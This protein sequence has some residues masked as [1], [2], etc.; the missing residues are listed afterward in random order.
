MGK[1]GW[2]RAL[3]DRLSRGA[4]AGEAERA[5]LLV[6]AWLVCG[7]ILLLTG[8]LYGATGLWAQAAIQVATVGAGA[9]VLRFFTL[10]RRLQPALHASL[11]VGSLTFA[12]GS[13]AQSPPDISSVAWLALA[14]LAASLLFGARAVLTWLAIEVALA[15]AIV[16]LG[17]A[18][19]HLDQR[20]SMPQVTTATNFILMFVVTA[21][22]GWSYR[23][24]ARRLARSEAESRA[25][26]T[27]LA[28]I[29]HEMR[30]PLNGMLGLT[31]LLLV[32][33]AD[34]ERRERLRTLLRSGRAL[35]DLVNDLLDFSSVEAG[36]VT[37]QPSPTDVDELVV[38]LRRLF[39]PLAQERQLTLAVDVRAPGSPV[40]VDGLRLRQ[41]LSN[42]LANAIKFTERGQ[43]RL[44]VLA[45]APGDDGLSSVTFAVADSGVGMSP[46]ALPRLRQPFEQGHP[47]GPRHR[48]GIGLGLAVADQ[49]V[50]LLGGALR[51][52]TAPG[53]GSRL[54]FELRLAP[55]VRPA[56]Y[57]TPL[58]AA[59]LGP[60]SVLVVDDNALNLRVA[61]ALVARA[62]YSV[63]TAS[64]GEEALAEVRAHHFAAVLMDCH[65][66]V[67]D[68]FECTRRIR[69]LGGDAGRT[70]VI[71]VSASAEPDD[72]AACHAAG[73]CEFVA[74]P[75]S[76]QTLV[77]SLER[78]IRKSGELDAGR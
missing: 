38:D 40:Q 55:A 11:V 73:M 70:P 61:S 20:D 66:P 15:T 36:K 35:A 54:S 9:L 42:L 76:Y 78:C 19:V 49:L 56:V 29:S 21:L 14:P 25:K 5:R 53:R 31:E 41:V 63:V 71:A 13:L 44:E 3:V 16:L 18:G 64:N 10:T 74:K 43:V 59:V 6:S 34:P 12:L 28:T 47:A 52:D 51:V 4:A 22:F 62:G 2:F 27:F 69:Q 75:V 8:S 50:T 67:L 39:E 17:H 30:T 26:S 37:L 68:G 32:D 65:M 72:V 7:P 23:R 58:P 60:L 1:P 57:L 48:G 33:E 46:E 24:R 77:T 45:D